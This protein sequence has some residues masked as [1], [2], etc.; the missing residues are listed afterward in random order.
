ME[1]YDKAFSYLEKN[2]ALNSSSVTA[3]QADALDD[4]LFGGI[5]FD[6]I[7]SNPPYLT[8]EEMD[9]LSPEV[10]REP[11]TAL[12]GGKDGLDFYRKL[13]PLWS[14]RL[15]ENGAFIVEVGDAQAD[16]VEKLMKEA[17]LYARSEKDAGGFRRAVIA[18][19]QI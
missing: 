8:A 4:S 13:I 10:S 16:D 12:D 5:S 11:R 7:T 2:K 9:S 19:R 18:G 6:V 17:G 15:S 14:P 3:V 1:L